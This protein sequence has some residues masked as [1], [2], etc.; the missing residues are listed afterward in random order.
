MGA[1]IIEKQDFKQ[2]RVR[3]YYEQD[4]IKKEHSSL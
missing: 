2:E 1:K 3:R 4:R